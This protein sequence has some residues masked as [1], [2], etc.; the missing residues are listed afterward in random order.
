MSPHVAERL[1]AY[2][3]GALP[4][5]DLE[6]VQA[7]LEI[8]AACGRAYDELRALRGLLR[9]LPDPAV[10]AGL[11]ERIHWRLA[12][13]EADYRPSPWD[14]VRAWL[15]RP[16]VARPLRLAL[17]GATALIVMGLPLGW[18][19]GWF[20]PRGTSFD[21]DAYVRDYLLLSSDRLTDDVTRT[22]IANTALPE[23][24]SS[25]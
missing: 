16:P 15:P 4:A 3:D 21:A 25:R 8:C 24:T 13:E 1:S 17:A 10:P 14:A 9:G 23:S 22:V 20:V 2:L 5:S 11:A 6:H 12:R 19:S 7:H 18:V